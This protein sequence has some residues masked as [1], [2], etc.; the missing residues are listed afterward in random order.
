[1]ESDMK[2]SFTRKV[3]LHGPPAMLL[4]AAMVLALAAGCGDLNDEPSQGGMRV[5]VG[6]S[7]TTSSSTAESGSQTTS[8]S[9]QA[10]TSPTVGTPVLSLIVGAIVIRHEK[11]VGSG[12]QPYTTGDATNLTIRQRD[13]LEAEAEQS[14]E[15]I[16]L[17]Q[18]PHP[19]DFV[20][21]TLPPT[22]AGPWQLVGVGLQHSIKTLDQIQ[23]DSPIYYGFIGQFLNGQIVPGQPTFTLSLE[24]ACLLPQ[25]PVT[26][27]P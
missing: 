5:T 24:P 1:M 27:C 2:N 8:S 15:F 11:N 19:T 13:L 17:V 12:I 14:V 3:G 25:A 26:P 9:P 4:G 20:E 21:F 10:I 22:N 7:D 6:F 23:G 16:E 18:L